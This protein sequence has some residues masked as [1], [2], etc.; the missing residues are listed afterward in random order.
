MPSKPDG[1]TAL[2]RIKI[3]WRG[4]RS[5]TALSV[6]QAV[7]CQPCIGMNCRDAAVAPELVA[8]RTAEPKKR[9]SGEI[10]ASSVNE[11][12]RAFICPAAACIAASAFRTTRAYNSNRSEER[13]VGKDCVNT[14]RKRGAEIE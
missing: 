8:W 7:Y 1:P 13:R 9:C 11:L 3:A 2:S 6:M 12:L 4:K 10:S 14:W 5:E